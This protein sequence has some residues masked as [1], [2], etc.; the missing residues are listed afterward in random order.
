MPGRSDSR[1]VFPIHDLADDLDPDLAEILPAID[2]LTGCDT[3]SKV[4][5]K[6]KASFIEGANN[7][8]ELLYSFGRNELSD[9][10]TD[11]EKFLLKCITKHA[12]DT[13]NQL[14]FI[15]YHEKHQQFD[16]ERFPTTS[17]SI[18]QH[19]LRAYLQCYIWLHA[20]F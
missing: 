8:Y 19:I 7:D 16:I 4:G 14:R 11:A 2:A 18:R 6:S 12:V 5:T 17:D 1:N 13:F 20:P 9:D 15:V 10:I 3:A